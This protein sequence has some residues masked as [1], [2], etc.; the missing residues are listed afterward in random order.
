MMKDEMDC[1]ECR[2]KII[3]RHGNF[4]W[5]MLLYLKGISWTSHAFLAPTPPAIPHAAIAA[6]ISIPSL[7]LFEKFF[8]MCSL[9]SVYA[10]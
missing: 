3:F 5:E 7:P 9:Y 2:R 8:S 6:S 10:T 1:L 4:G